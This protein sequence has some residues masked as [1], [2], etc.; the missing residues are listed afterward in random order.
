MHIFFN[1]YL[2]IGLNK[3]TSLDGAIG[4]GKKE[5]N[6]VGMTGGRK[7]E[8]E[9]GDNYDTVNGV[10][11]RSDINNDCAVIARTHTIETGN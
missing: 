10:T 6:G 9:N 4:R 7:G 3:G 11:V 8:T 2:Y 5:E 1:L